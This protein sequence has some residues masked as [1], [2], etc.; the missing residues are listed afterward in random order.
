MRKSFATTLFDRASSDH[1]I[2]LL[3]GDLGFGL[4]DDFRDYMPGQFYNC[5]SSEQAMMDIAVG[6]ALAGKIPFV[7]SITPFLIYRAYETIRTYIVHEHLH[8]VLVGSGRNDDYLHDGYSHDASDVPDAV[9]TLGV[10]A[11]YPVTNGA[12]P[13]IVQTVLDTP[14]P[15]FLSLRR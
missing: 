14:G 3:T 1:H 11:Y 9:H 10:P 2:V 4:W 13:G 7:Y 15:H 12:I 6:L 5:G 8:V